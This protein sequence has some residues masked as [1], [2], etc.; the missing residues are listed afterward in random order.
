M[1]ICAV[2]D[3]LIVG[4]LARIPGAGFGYGFIGFRILLPLLIYAALLQ[5]IMEIEWEEALMVGV[6]TGFVKVVGTVAI[7]YWIASTFG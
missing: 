4:V 6:L 1:G 2:M 7:A 5:H 3:V